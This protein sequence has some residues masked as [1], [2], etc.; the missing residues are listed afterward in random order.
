MTA[1]SYQDGECF[2]AYV[3]FENGIGGKKRPV[4]LL[5]DQED[6]TFYACKVTGKVNKPKNQRYGYEVKDWVDAGLH[7][8]SI[9]KCNKHEIY[10]VEPEQL[11]DKIGQLSHRDLHGLLTKQIKVRM[12]E[13][14]KERVLEHGHEL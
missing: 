8:P 7:Q 14:E 1:I 10:E 12:L 13:K 3:Q 5:H 2:L 4:V 9:I 11:R 6:H